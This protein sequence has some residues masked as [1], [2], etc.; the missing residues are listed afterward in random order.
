MIKSL[1]FVKPESSK[2]KAHSGTRRRCRYPTLTVEVNITSSQEFGAFTPPTST[3][4]GKVLLSKLISVLAWEECRNWIKTRTD[5][6]LRKNSFP[7]QVTAFNRSTIPICAWTIPV[8]WSKRL[9]GESL[10]AR[11]HTSQPRLIDQHAHVQLI[12]PP[13]PS[14]LSSMPG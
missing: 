6:F 1:A 8:H 10:F 7:N 3:W 12:C 11:A 9:C 5:H 14:Q 2:N 13:T 4:G